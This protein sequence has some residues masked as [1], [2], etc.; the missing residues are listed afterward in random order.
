MKNLLIPGLL[1]AITLPPAAQAAK[2]KPPKSVVNKAWA[3]RLNLP[4]GSHWK[5]TGEGTF[6]LS[7]APFKGQD[8]IQSAILD[9]EVSK[10]TDGDAENPVDADPDAVIS[11]FVAGNLEWEKSVGGSAGAGHTMITVSYTAMTVSHQYHLVGILSAT[12]PELMEGSKVR[13]WDPDKAAQKVFDGIL[14]G[15]RSL[16]LP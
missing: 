14:N 9:L 7:L 8:W 10:V 11:K 6:E 3:F 4:K 2:P 1:L 5:E 13:S 12:N 15:F 16:D